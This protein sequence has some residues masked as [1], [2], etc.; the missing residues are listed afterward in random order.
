MRKLRYLT[1]DAVGLPGFS[2]HEGQFRGAQFLVGCSYEVD[3]IA[4]SF[5]IAGRCL[6]NIGVVT[7]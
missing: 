5:E 4:A 3:F 6:A 7:E 1:T 2:H